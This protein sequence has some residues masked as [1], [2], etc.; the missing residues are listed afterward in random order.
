MSTV[1]QIIVIRKDLKMRKGKMISQGCHASLAVI[2]NLMIND[3]PYVGED[4]EPIILNKRLKYERDSALDKW[5]SEKFTKIVVSVN[6]EQ[7]LLD[8]YNKAK[9]AGLYCSLI[10]DAGDTEFHSIPTLTCCA[11][12]PA[13]S[14]ELDPITGHLKL[15]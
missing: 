7:E 9:E 1:K 15:L 5:I 11:I 10:Q 8:I 3:L 12:G 2:L 14:E 6:S 4:N 13:Y